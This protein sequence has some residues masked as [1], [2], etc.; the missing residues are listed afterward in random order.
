M[1]DDITEFAHERGADGELLPVEKAVEIHGEETTVE[2]YPATTGERNEWRRRLEEAPD[3]LGT[4]TEA[5]L[6]DQFTVYDP[7]AFNASSWAEVRPA[8]VDALANA[9]FSELFDT[10]EDDFSKVVEE[11]MDDVTGNETAT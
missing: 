6:L 1:A 9:V 10:E 3:E 4:E 5:D 2:V 11:R 7:A 8:I